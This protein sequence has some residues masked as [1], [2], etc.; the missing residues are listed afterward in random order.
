M[1]S[2]EQRPRVRPA[3]GEVDGLL[4]PPDG[5]DAPVVRRQDRDAARSGA[6]N[7]ADAVDLHW[8]ASLSAKVSRVICG[9]PEGVCRTRFAHLATPQ[10]WC[11][12]IPPAIEMSK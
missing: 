4:R 6:R 1:G 12:G 2:T 5:A 11:R 9:N 8:T 7:P 3:K 10:R